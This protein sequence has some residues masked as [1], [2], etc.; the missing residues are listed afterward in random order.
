[1]NIV[2][3]GNK[4]KSG[5][6]ET[7]LPRYV[8]IKNKITDLREKKRSL[9]RKYFDTYNRLINGLDIDKRLFDKV[10]DD[11]ND[12][13]D[14]IETLI[15]L[16]T[17]KPSVDTTALEEEL[18]RLDTQ[19]ANIL[20][21]SVFD[22]KVGNTLARNFRRKVVIYNELKEIS[23]SRYNGFN[24]YMKVDG[25]AKAAV[26]EKTP[27]QSSVKKLSVDQKVEI[28]DNIKDLLKNVYRFKDKGECLSK[29]RSKAFYMSKEEI[30]QE[31]ENNENLKKLMPSNYKKLTKD[32]L[33][34]FF[35][36]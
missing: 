4:M 21:K 15:G 3:K 28:M 30:L 2:I 31:I 33:C 18:S 36:E 9:S 26:K 25:Y 12:I 35:F 7:V 17:N 22:T 13:E 27:K 34:E 19:D 8:N 20:K 14:E 24:E 1:M 32:K 5:K 10:V 23:E 16:R 29:Q 11:I 6:S